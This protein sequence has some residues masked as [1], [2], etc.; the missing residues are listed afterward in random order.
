M[1]RRKLNK[2]KELRLIIAL[3]A[4]LLLALGYLGGFLYF[5]NHFLPNTF[6][7]GI[8][9]SSLNMEAADLKLKD[10]EPVLEVIQK[11]KEGSDSIIETLQL[12]KLSQDISYD[13]G[14]L[15]K[16]QN[17]PAWF[18]SLFSKKELNC[19]KL[20][21][22]FVSTK[23][24]ELI[25]DLY[26]LKEENIDKPEDAHLAIQDGKVVL[27]E[28]VDGSYISQDK[29]KSIVTKTIEDCLTSNGSLS[30][31]LRN[32]YEMPSIREDDPQFEGIITNL[33]KIL[34]KTIQINIDSNQD[35]T[36]EDQELSDLLKIENNEM[37]IDEDNLS[38]YISSFCRQY[39]VSDYEYI[40]RSSFKRDLEDALLQDEDETINI[41]WVYEE[42]NK[43]IEVSISNQ[44]LYYYED[45]VLIMTSPIVTGNAAITGPTPTGYF[46]IRRMKQDSI[47]FGADYTEHVDYWIGFD[48][49]GRVYGFHD[50]SWRDEFGGDIYLSDPSRGCVNM[51]LEKIAQL[52]DYVDIGTEVHIYE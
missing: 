24:D 27:L 15:L 20:S 47:L 43:L 6:I 11:N 32:D 42:I 14:N 41:N 48:E 52:W 51:P 46:T 1:K 30:I 39:D 50:A 5:R 10:S 19:D 33:Q 35:T 13:S 29:V 44:T 17:A 31:D 3:A 18:V 37:A 7:N 22:S 2:K 36:I 21:G 28:A 49:T 8:K 34:D 16:N 23:I 25:K 12:R 45:D 9:V 4:I 40:E 26:C 38:S